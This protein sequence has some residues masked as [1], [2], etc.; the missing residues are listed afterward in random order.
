MIGMIGP[1]KAR[2]III[3]NWELIPFVYKFVIGVFALPLILIVTFFTFKLIEG[4]LFDSPLQAII[5]MC[6]VISISLFTYAYVSELVMI[7]K[8]N[9][10][11]SDRRIARIEVHDR[12]IQKI[13]NKIRIF[14]RIYILGIILTIIFFCCMAVF[15][16]RINQLRDELNE[17][18]RESDEITIEE[19]RQRLDEINQELDRFWIY[20]FI[21]MMLMFIGGTLFTIGNRYKKFQELR[22]SYIGQSEIGT[23][24]SFIV[25]SKEE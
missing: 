25:D 16:F 20:N 13:E 10:K 24:L 17:L 4:F 8:Y 23:K 5:I 7:K 14:K 6:L 11:V 22:E 9:L 19:H 1:I 21:I 12:E 2:K 18:D 15:M 3:Q